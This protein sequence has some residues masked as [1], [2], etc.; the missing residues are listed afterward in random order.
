MAGRTWTEAEAAVVRENA[1]ALT[2]QD[3]GAMIDRTTDAVRNWA[4]A[5]GIGLATPEKLSLA[6]RRGVAAR[7]R[8]AHAAGCKRS[9]QGNAERKAALSKI[10]SERLAVGAFGLK[11]VARS[12][13]TTVKQ[14][15][16]MLRMWERRRA[17][18]RAAE[19]IAAM[20][21]FERM[22]HRVQNGAQIV[23]LHRHTYS[24][25]ERTLGGVASYG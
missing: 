1:K 22:L 4:R 7:D 8:A 23:E 9:W 6:G 12:P 18:S 11:G 16:A 2:A 25:T 20:T 17:S 19:R 15:E 5:N 21:P 10:T 3:I 14:R 24:P 13:E